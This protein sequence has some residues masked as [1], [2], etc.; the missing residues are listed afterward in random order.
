MKFTTNPKNGFIEAIWLETPIRTKDNTVVIIASFNFKLKWTSTNISIAVMAHTPT[1]LLALP[2]TAPY[3]V[4][5]ITIPIIKIKLLIRILGFRFFFIL[6]IILSI[7]LFHLVIS[8]VEHYT[9]FKIL[10][11]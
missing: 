6:F 9:T 4:T 10:V 11:K 3:K 8:S 2:K 7:P 1:R 5:K